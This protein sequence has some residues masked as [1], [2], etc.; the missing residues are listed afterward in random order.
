MV[1]SDEGAR[2][3][4]FLGTQFHTGLETS[5][6]GHEVAWQGIAAVHLLSS[7]AGTD[8]LDRRTDRLGVWQP[9]PAA[10]LLAAGSDGLRLPG[11][12]DAVPWGL[13]AFHVTRPM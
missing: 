10:I 8:I 11:H 3:P 2:L 1:L 6:T 9:F 7:G 13:I 4:C 12:R 5:T